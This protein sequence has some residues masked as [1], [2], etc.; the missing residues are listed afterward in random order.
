ME[1]LAAFSSLYGHEK[2]MINYSFLTSVNVIPSLM[3]IQHSASTMMRSKSCCEGL[4]LD[5]VLEGLGCHGYSR[6]LQVFELSS[7][8]V[9]WH[10]GCCGV[11]KEAH[12][13]IHLLSSTNP[14]VY[15]DSL[16]RRE[17]TDSRLLS[18]RRS[19][20]AESV[21]KSCLCLVVKIQRCLSLSE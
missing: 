18:L 3:L 21:I 9:D 6:G 12:T 7:C 11:L 14:L 8:L 20:R 2:W 16:S 10:L 1:S 17:R 13:V 19:Q 4:F 5:I 15:K